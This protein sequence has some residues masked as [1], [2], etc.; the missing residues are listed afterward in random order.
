VR[1]WILAA[2]AVIH[3]SCTTGI[4]SALMGTPAIALCPVTNEELDVK[5]ANDSSTKARSQEELC[6]LVGDCLAG[7]PPPALLLQPEQ[8]QVLQRFFHL[9]DG[10]AADR[11]AAAITACD[12][13]ASAD[14]SAIRSTWRR[15]CKRLLNRLTPRGCTET[16]VQ[17]LHPGSRSQQYTRQQF[18]ALSSS[19]LRAM[20]ETFRGLDPDLPAPVV[21]P[22][23]GCQDCFWLEPG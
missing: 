14:T 1:S 17:F 5:V 13:P 12:S 4:E 3:N 16:V 21:R 6:Q 10:C 9:L 23:R 7:S 18:P 15:R 8:L 19:E 11:A 2:S 20:I 22:L